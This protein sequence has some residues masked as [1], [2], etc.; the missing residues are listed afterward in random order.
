[1]AAVTPE[2]AV[3][4]AALIYAALVIIPTTI[5]VL[6][7]IADARTVPVWAAKC[8]AGL[9]PTPAGYEGRRRDRCAAA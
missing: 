9:P 4:T 3:M 5:I 8:T 2:S 1:M 7:V 6:W